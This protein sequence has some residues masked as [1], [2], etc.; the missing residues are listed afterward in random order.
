MRKAETPEAWHTLNI[1]RTLGRGTN[2]WGVAEIDYFRVTL[3]LREPSFPSRGL[4]LIST[5][6]AVLL[7]INIATRQ[8][9]G[10][11]FSTSR[12]ER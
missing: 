4:K 3:W 8:F 5:S 9:V 10:F 2:D 7:V 1:R 6:L 12:N 11:D